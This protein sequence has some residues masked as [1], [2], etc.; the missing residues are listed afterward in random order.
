MYFK[1][2][3]KTNAL[4]TE[5]VKKVKYI[6]TYIIYAYITKEIKG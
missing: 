3:F 4:F 2:L 6:H 5:N 1:T